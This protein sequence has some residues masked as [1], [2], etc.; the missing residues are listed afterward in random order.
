[1]KDYAEH[2]TEA[3]TQYG[4]LFS[5]KYKS[6]KRKLLIMVKIRSS[7][8]S[9]KYGAYVSDS[10]TKFTNVLKELSWIFQIEQM[11]HTSP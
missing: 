7:L 1:M 10:N 11:N 5:S 8:G 2:C 6:L 4:L 9:M 3:G